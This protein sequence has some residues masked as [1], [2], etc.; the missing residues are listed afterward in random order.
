MQTNS[1]DARSYAKNPRLDF[2][3]WAMSM[4]IVAVEILLLPS[5]W[6]HDRFRQ[7]LDGTSTPSRPSHRLIATVL[8]QHRIDLDPTYWKLVI[9]RS[10]RKAHVR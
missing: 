2:I 6:R 7:S 5:R 8:L 4:T 1:C 9:D 3:N 10:W